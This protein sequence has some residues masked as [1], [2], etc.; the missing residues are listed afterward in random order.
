MTPTTADFLKICFSTVL[1]FAAHLRLGL[2]AAHES[3]AL[4]SERCSETQR[5]SL[6]RAPTYVIGY[7][8]AP[9]PRAA[10]CHSSDAEFVVGGSLPAALRFLDHASSFQ[11]PSHPWYRPRCLQISG[12]TSTVG[13]LFLGKTQSDLA[14]TFGPRSSGRK[15]VSWSLHCGAG[16]YRQR[17]ASLGAAL[18]RTGSGAYQQKFDHGVFLRRDK[19]GYEQLQEYKGEVSGQISTSL[20]LDTRRE[21]GFNR[22]YRHPQPKTAKTQVVSVHTASDK[23]DPHNSIAITRLVRFQ[24]RM[25]NSSAIWSTLRG[26]PRSREVA[27]RDLDEEG[28]EAVQVRRDVSGMEDGDGGENGGAGD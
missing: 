4:K 15:W 14:F 28:Q 12:A 22:L 5:P 2:L 18:G 17:L 16:C 6:S 1:P 27:S 20:Q 7:Q 11:H 3:T 8:R 19:P 9:T 24:G 21:E 10:A 25:W 26:A 13:M 23:P